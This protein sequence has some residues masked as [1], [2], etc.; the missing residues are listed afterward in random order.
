MYKKSI[1]SGFKKGLMTIWNLTKIVVPVYFF[2]TF[3][4]YTPVLNRISTFFEPA[5]KIIGLPGETS[6]V[7][8]LGN[9]VS[10]YAGLGAMAGL[11][12]TTKQATILAIMLS[13]SHGLFLETAVVKKV[14]VSSTIAILTRVLLALLSAFIF[15]LI[16]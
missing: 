10:L 15:N 12:L 4:G 6:L 11:S 13:I 2:V 1:I 8:V 9:L 3:L 5:M 16:L 14:G 7:L